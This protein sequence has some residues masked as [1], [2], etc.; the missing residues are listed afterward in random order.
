MWK[1]G[2]YFDPKSSL[3]KLLIKVFIYSKSVHQV[4][5]IIPD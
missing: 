1:I 4:S 2:L 5:E 3:T